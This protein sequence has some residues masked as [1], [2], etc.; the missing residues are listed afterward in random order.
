MKSV[1][2]RKMINV[3]IFQTALKVILLNT[4]GDKFDANG[5]GNLW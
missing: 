2:K 4:V 3:L 5:F 1:I